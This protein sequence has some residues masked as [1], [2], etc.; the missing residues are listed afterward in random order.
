[1]TTVALCDSSEAAAALHLP[2]GLH[3]AIWSLPHSLV[4]VRLLLA[5]KWQYTWFMDPLAG[6]LLLPQRWSVTPSRNGNSSIT[7]SQQHY[8]T[9]QFN[10]CSACCG[11]NLG[12]RME[13]FFLFVLNLSHG[14]LWHCLKTI[15]PVYHMLTVLVG[16]SN[17]G[18]KSDKPLTL[19]AKC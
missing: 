12:V 14:F 11:L 4:T 5:L 2:L 19:N 16:K 9:K 13:T 10:I 18:W 7:D 15:W 17:L 8:W 1:M 6:V 3:L